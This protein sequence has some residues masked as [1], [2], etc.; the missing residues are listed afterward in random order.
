MGIE[1]H[2]PTLHTHGL[3]PFILP[4][5]TVWP[6]SKNKNVSNLPIVGV[7]LFDWTAAAQSMNFTDFAAKVPSGHE[8]NKRLF[9]KINQEI[10]VYNPEEI[11]LL[12]DKPFY[13]HARRRFMYTQSRYVKPS[14]QPLCRYDPITQEGIRPENLITP[15]HMFPLSQ[16]LAT[17]WSKIELARYICHTFWD[18][19]QSRPEHIVFDTPLC[20]D[21]VLC[22]G[23]IKCNKL[24]CSL[25]VHTAIIPRH[26]EADVLF[27]HHIQHLAPR[28]LH[29]K[30]LVGGTNDRDLLVTL[31]CAFN[32][33]LAKQIIFRTHTRPYKFTPD[34]WVKAAEKVI[35]VVEHCH[36]YINMG[37]VWLMFGG[38]N[39][40]LLLTRL[41]I[42]FLYKSDYCAKPDGLTH[43]GLDYALF[44]Q[45]T[46]F[47]FLQKDQ[48]LKL[49]LTQ[50][51]YFIQKAQENSIRPKTPMNAANLMRT[52]YDA[53]YCL[54][55][56]TAYHPLCEP[57]NLQ[58][59]RNAD[60]SAYIGNST[61]LSEFEK[62][63]RVQMFDLDEVD[64]FVTYY[65]DGIANKD[66]NADLFFSPR[67]QARKDD[68]VP[69]DIDHT[70]KKM[71]IEH[72]DVTTTY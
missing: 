65:K 49:S 46:P 13:A 6:D 14:K 27:L 38:A 23:T 12:F 45:T 52:M 61:L 57:D 70:N 42:L 51:K 37:D 66:I 17:E 64:V 22:D 10:L 53:F 39:T 55:Y 5:S 28:H 15:T 11:C 43:K 9:G 26:C 30:M 33:D 21:D 72:I 47:L 4:V 19:A 58:F 67:K 60:G 7:V 31:S 8:F 20:P 25:C 18:W 68:H 41:F 63:L 36:E 34:G 24:Q 2:W 40:D 62:F 16:L 54:I 1:I 35:G 32:G 71:A 56:Y 48:S 50:Y 29:K 59:A 44:Q 69:N 3:K